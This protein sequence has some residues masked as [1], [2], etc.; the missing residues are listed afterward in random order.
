[1]YENPFAAGLVQLWAHETLR[2]FH[3]RLICDEDRNWLLD[4]IRTQVDGTLGVKF[5]S[6]FPCS[7]ADSDP[8][9]GLQELM[10]CNFGKV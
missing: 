7:S 3:D 2:V 10:Y 8:L 1:M 9:G 5:S 6:T 4:C